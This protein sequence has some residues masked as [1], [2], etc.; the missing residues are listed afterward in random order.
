MRLFAGLR[1][2]AGRDELE[3]ELPDG[4]RVA[5]AL[6]QVQHLAPGTSLVLAVNREYA[7][8]DV[9]LVEGDEL[10][11]VPPVS[12]GEVVE[13]ELSLDAVAARVADPR[14]GA[15]V[16]FSGVTRDVDF[17]DYE[18]YAEMAGAKIDAIVAE[19]IERHGLCRAAADHRFGRV[20]LGEASVVVAASAPHRPE[21]FAGA[22]EIIDRIKA[23]AP[24]WKREEGAWVEGTVPAEAPVAA[25]E[26]PAPAA[27]D[28][29]PAADPPPAAGPVLDVSVDARLEHGARVLVVSGSD[30]A[31]ARVGWLGGRFHQLRCEEPFPAAA[32]RGAVVEVRRLRDDELLGEA[33][34]LDPDA[35]RHGPTNDA[36]VRL[37][38][39]ERGDEPRPDASIAPPPLDAEAQALE[40]RYRDAGT[41]PP[42][43]AE[44][45]PDERAA[46][47]ALREAGRVVLLERGRHVHVD[48]G[49]A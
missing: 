12:G 9:V 41:Q 45:S 29:P 36:L 10:A 48:F 37:V 49:P 25:P 40:Q 11:V 46:L 31:V 28:A 38:A 30:E 39:L 14:A 17:L 23:E 34:V 6:A 18:A 8:R 13:G 33:T 7:A 5:D 24:I 15:V 1:E 3:L 20:P 22:R 32:R 42:R 35:A 4:A 26:S 16:T 47:F 43:D 21:A 44:L 27:P 2:A 19:A